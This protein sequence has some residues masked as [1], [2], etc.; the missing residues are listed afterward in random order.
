VGGRRRHDGCGDGCPYIPG[1][2]YIAWQLPDPAGR[3]LDEVRAIR[4]QIAERI[5][6]LVGALDRAQATTS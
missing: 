2:R 1:K 4:D 6:E 3:P 5:E